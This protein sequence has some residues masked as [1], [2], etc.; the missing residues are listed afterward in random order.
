LKKLIPFIVVSAFTLSGCMNAVIV[1][2]RPDG[3]EIRLLFYP[4]GSILDDL[5]IIDGVNYF[6]TAQY[7]VDDPLADVGFRL[8]SGERVQAECVSVVKNF[9]DKDE[10]ARY[11]IYRSSFGLIP[12]G[13]IFDRPK[14]F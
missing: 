12:E 13:S 7:Q 6:G 8:K 1:G 4:G 14:M 10:C 5:I 11:E 9:M 3:S 2:T